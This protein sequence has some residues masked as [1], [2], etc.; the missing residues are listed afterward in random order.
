MNKKKGNLFIVSAPSGTGKTTL[1]KAALSQFVNLQY[2]VS[3]TTRSP[4]QGE[5]D[6]VDYFFITKKE[7][8]KKIAEDKWAEWASVHD[9]Y[10]GTSAEF[11]DEKLSAG[12]DILLDIDVQGAE[13]ILSKFPDCV[14]IFIMP[15]SPDALQARLSK[16]GTDS[17]EVI[18]KRL[19]NAEKEIEKKGM[20]RHIIVND[21]LQVAIDELISIMESYD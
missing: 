3:S 12:I 4:R 20:Y 19:I 8:E 10:Y 2:S 16:R 15:P 5:Q 9:N 14:T 7:F 13:Q 17:E 1:C 18:A 11:L 6:G 21:K